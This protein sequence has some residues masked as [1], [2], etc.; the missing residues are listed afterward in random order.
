MGFHSDPK[1]LTPATAVALRDRPFP[2]VNGCRINLCVGNLRDTLRAAMV[3]S[4]AGYLTIPSDKCT[5]VPAHN[6]NCN[7]SSTKRNRSKSP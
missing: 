4:L 7:S 2:S 5:T 3:E 1:K 6:C